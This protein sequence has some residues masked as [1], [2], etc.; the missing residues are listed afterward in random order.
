MLGEPRRSARPRQADDAEAMKFAALGPVFLLVPGGLCAGGNTDGL[1]SRDRGGD[2]GPSTARASARASKA[3][4]V[5]RFGIR[6]AAKDAAASRD[7]FSGLLAGVDDAR[8]LA[9]AGVW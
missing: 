6:R 1:A 3:V 7:L 2:P 8:K 5:A 4:P 9:F